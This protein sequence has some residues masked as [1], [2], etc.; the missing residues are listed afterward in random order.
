MKFIHNFV[1]CILF[2]VSVLIVISV[3]V[4]VISDTRGDKVWG[5][6]YQFIFVSASLLLSMVI[7]ILA[8]GI[9]KRKR[10]SPW[11]LLLIICFWVFLNVEG[12]LSLVS[13]TNVHIYEDAVFLG[14]STCAPLVYMWALFKETTPMSRKGYSCD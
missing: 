14:V 8:F 3:G 1:A 11:F 5:S 12:F 9:F 2:A 4:G 6:S 10:W 7:F 13:G